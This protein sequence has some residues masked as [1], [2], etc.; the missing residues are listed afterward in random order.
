MPIMGQILFSLVYV[1]VIILF[2]VLIRAILRISR[3][4]DKIADSL[5]KR[6][7]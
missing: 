2:I 3:A 5:S 1:G 7:P 4:V 6:E